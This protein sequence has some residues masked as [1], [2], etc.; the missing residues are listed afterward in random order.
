MKEMMMMI[1]IGIDID[2]AKFISGCWKCFAVMQFQ[3]I[4]L[5]SN[6]KTRQVK[7]FQPIMTTNVY[8]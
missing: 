6:Y 2:K 8:E 7:C 4:F 3:S 1:I 5:R